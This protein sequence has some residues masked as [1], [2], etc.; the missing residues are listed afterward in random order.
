MGTSA[1]KAGIPVAAAEVGGSGAGVVARGGRGAPARG[2]GG[3]GFWAGLDRRP[4]Q[5]GPPPSRLAAAWRQRRGGGRKLVGGA[6]NA[7]PCGGIRRR[8]RVVRLAARWLGG[9][10]D[11]GR[12]AGERRETPIFSIFPTLSAT[13]KQL[14][15]FFGNQLV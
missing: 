2:C 10:E 1:G 3:A 9:Q 4:C 6:R 12:R 13:D 5:W 15:R 14:T 11:Q 7:S 8:G